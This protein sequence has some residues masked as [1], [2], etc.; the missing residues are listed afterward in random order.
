MEKSRFLHGRAS[1][2]YLRRPQA[3]RRALQSSS[4]PPPT[5]HGTFAYRIAASYTAK[6]RRYRP[7]VNSF[8]FNPN[9][10]IQ[11]HRKDRRTR[12]DSGE[13]AFFIT[14]VGET[15]AVA[16]GVADGVGG[17]SNS[18]IDPSDFSHGLCDYMAGAAYEHIGDELPALTAQGLMQRGYDDVLRDKGVYAGGSTACVAIA[19]E[20]GMLECANLG[21]SGYMQ[22]RLNAVRSQ[23][24]PQ[25]HA[26][27]TPYQLSKVPAMMRARSAA[28][29]GSQLCDYPTDASVTRHEV[30]H[31]D[32]LVFATDG[33]W[34]NLSSQDV[35]RIVSRLMVG[36][37]AWTTST[38]G[39]AVGEKLEK[40]TTVENGTSGPQKVLSLQS[41]LA[42]AI[43]GEAKAAST[44]TKHDGPFAKEVKRYYPHENWRGGKVDDICVVVAI[45]IEE[46][47]R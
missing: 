22:L 12:P 21:D 25:T 11:K 10:R 9:L 13:D 47:R 15:D 42:A 20:N 27:N 14:R 41:Y 7:E 36:V 2:S 24:D 19:R 44:N 35:L 32:V 23:S 4:A 3:Q 26:F 5:S 45:V 8:T 37:R 43:T 16:F 18:G 1:S 17:W 29:G 6:D 33:C 40:L 31:G 46:G 30:K 38:D 28:F 34:D 39:T